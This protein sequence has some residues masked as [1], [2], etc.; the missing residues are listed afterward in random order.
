M[1]T[2][3]SDGAVPEQDEAVA[4]A[5]ALAR[6]DVPEAARLAGLIRYG[7]EV[8]DGAPGVGMVDGTRVLLAFVTFEAW[9]R[10]GSDHEIRLLA[11][12]LFAT[13]A[14]NSRVDAVLFE[15]SLDRATQVPLSDVLALLR[16]EAADDDGSRL[17][18]DVR[19]LPFPALHAQVS[20]A[21]GPE[22]SGSA[23]GAWALCR[24]SPGGSVPLIAV[25]PEADDEQ[26]AALVE[27]LSRHELPA[28][29]E[30]I[31]LDGADAGFVDATW[32]AVRL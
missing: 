14:A 25:A 15:P 9:Q 1:T 20:E 8:V 26:V 23:G 16:G 22:G 11:P 19:V 7:I 5:D 24:V 32:S 2:S 10:F 27:R 3:G 30:V 18:G 6:Q 13:V 31:R 4:F 29:L 28:D 21:L 17:M 12:E